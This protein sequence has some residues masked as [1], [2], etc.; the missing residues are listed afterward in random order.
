MGR[1]LL[2]WV[3]IMESNYVVSFQLFDLKKRQRKRRKDQKQNFFF[4]SD[5]CWIF[6]FLF[7]FFYFLGS[8]LDS[9]FF[10]FSYCLLFSLTPI[11]DVVFDILLVNDQTV[12]ELTLEQRF[13]LIK[14]CIPNPQPKILG[15]L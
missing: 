5:L 14:R 2:M 8:I 3:E 10:P 12:M 11:L 9:S 4:Q 13:E 7:R 6:T 1:E 15:L